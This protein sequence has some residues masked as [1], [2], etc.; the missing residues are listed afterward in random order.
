VN[1]KSGEASSSDV[2]ELYEF[3]LFLLDMMSKVVWIVTL[4]NLVVFL[5]ALTLMIK[6]LRGQELGQVQSS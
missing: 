2:H 6:D 5:Y 4:I 1:S 3:L